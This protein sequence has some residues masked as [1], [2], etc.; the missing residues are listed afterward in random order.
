MDFREL[1]E[2]E[3]AEGWEWDADWPTKRRRGRTRREKRGAKSASGRAGPK[4][5]RGMRGHMKS[6]PLMEESDGVE[7]ARG[8]TKNAPS[9]AWLSGAIRAAVSS[10]L[11]PR[12]VPPEM[13]MH[14]EANRVGYATLAD[15]PSWLRRYGGASVEPCFLHGAKSRSVA[16]GKVGTLIL[17]KLGVAFY[18]WSDESVAFFHPW[19]AIPCW[20]SYQ[21]RGLNNRFGGYLVSSPHNG[22]KRTAISFYFASREDNARFS[23]SGPHIIDALVMHARKSATPEKRADDDRILEAALSVQ[24]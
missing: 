9:V 18:S 4:P 3:S 19:S 15:D 13:A 6:L 1:L 22:R 2:E 7:V 5:T 8:A 14:A 11:S 12:T 16:R 10:K 17:F 20:G 23:F 24:D 21:H